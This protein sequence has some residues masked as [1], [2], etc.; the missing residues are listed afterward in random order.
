MGS[1]IDAKDCSHLLSM[2]KSHV[3][4][5]LNDPHEEFEFLGDDYRVMRP[6]TLPTP[7]KQTYGRSLAGNKWLYSSRCPRIMYPSDSDAAEILQ[8]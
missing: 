1:G 4:D 5:Q 7:I 2:Y 6:F 3:I 8:C